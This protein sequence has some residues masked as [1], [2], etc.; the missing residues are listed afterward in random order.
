MK[1]IK[2][3]V[4]TANTFEFV[5]VPENLPS[6]L[7]KAFCQGLIRRQKLRKTP[8]DKAA[9]NVFIKSYFLQLKYVKYI[10][11]LIIMSLND[12]SIALL[13]LIAHN[14]LKMDKAAKYTYDF[15]GEI[16]FVLYDND[17]VKKTENI[18]YK[19]NIT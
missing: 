16:R 3:T 11:T 14:I 15:I 19:I 4:K 2:K 10:R 9:I 1:Y 17:F 7:K 13:K 18:T 5:N 6:S 12:I 8:V